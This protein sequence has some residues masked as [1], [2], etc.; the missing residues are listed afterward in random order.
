M[1]LFPVLIRFIECIAFLALSCGRPS[2]VQWTE[3][4]T[5]PRIL[6]DITDGT[7]PPNITPLNFKILESGDSYE[8]RI[9][10][11]DGA[12]IRI[13]TGSQGI[14]IPEKKWKALLKR[15]SGDTLQIEIFVK[16]EGRWN[17]FQPFSLIVA[18]EPIDTHLVYR[19]IGPVYMYWNKIKLVERNLTNFVARDL[20]NNRDHGTMCM[21]C[22]AFAAGNPE[23]M[24]VHIRRGPGTGML[25]SDSGKLSNIDTKTDF[26]PPAAMPAFHPDGSR[27]AFSVNQFKQFFHALGE[28]RDVVDLA[29]DIILYDIPSNT[30]T[31]TPDLAAP[32]WLETWPA[33]SADGKT[34]YFCR[35]PQPEK[36]N[37]PYSEIM[38][39]RYDLAAVDFDPATGKFGTV[40]T[41]L[42][43]EETGKSISEPRVSPDGKFL[44][45]CMADY[46]NFFTFRESSD[47]Y[48]R[49]LK[50]GE[51]RRAECSSD[52]AETW[53]SWSSN[54]RWIVFSSKRYD[55]VMTRPCFAY[56]D[57]EGRTRKPFALPHEDPE[58][59]EVDM[60]NYHLPELITGPVPNSESDFIKAAYDLEHQIPVH[61]DPAVQV[62]ENQAKP[63]EMWLPGKQ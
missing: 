18:K 50:S 19:Q 62:P 4:Q 54:S 5:L 20:M 1:K 43:A 30:I 9:S 29:S 32:D 55:G 24:M 56:V 40:R 33:W 59:Y 11:N 2:A 42:S 8:V 41:V 60:F 17:R 51:F 34:L 61:L 37:M 38:K 15:N 7:I 3:T 26:N 46:G 63:P 16:S 22:H 28:N 53:H 10:G 57:K 45:F 23:R 52:R 36:W 49:D 27:I 44:L 12:S 6:P 48:M 21:N 47:L 35:S 13:R 25:L 58:Y 14:R 31:T 39:I